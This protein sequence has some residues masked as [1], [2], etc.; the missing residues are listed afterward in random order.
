MIRSQD[1]KEGKNDMKLL[2]LI[3]AGAVL[4]LLA[5]FIL[6]LLSAALLQ[7]AYLFLDYH[8]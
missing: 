7:K 6:F 1:R 2:L 8:R 4:T 5:F 3:L